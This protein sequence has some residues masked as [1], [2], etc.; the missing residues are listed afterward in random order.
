MNKKILHITTIDVSHKEI[1]IDKMSELQ[2]LGYEIDL[3]SDVTVT[4]YQETP[5]VDEIKR[6]G[7]T[8]IKV[9]MSRSI[10]PFKDLRSIYSIWRYLRK[11]KYSVVHT[12][13]AKAGLIGRIAARLA[14]Q[15]IVVHTSHGLPFYDGQSKIK[16]N[17]YKTLEKAA[18]YFSDGY[19]SQ[20]YEDLVEIKKIVPKRLLTGYEGNGIDLEKL[21]MISNPTPS[22]IN[23]FRKSLNIS[24]NDFLFLIGA[25]LEKVKNHEMLINAVKNTKNKNF[26]ILLAGKGELEES[27]KNK[28]KEFN[29]QDKVLFLGYRNDIVHLIQ[30][31][32]AV[33]LTSE[34]EGIPRILM[35]SMA[36][37]KPVL[38]TSVLGT[39]ELVIHNQTGELVTLND[40]DTLAKTI[41]KWTNKE[42]KTSLIKYGENGR[43]RIIEEYTEAK[44]AERINDFYQILFKKTDQ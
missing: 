24:K 1:M 25:R 18:S 12:H 26:K 3:M 10:Q 8:H 9:K 5:Y 36:F 41:D 23:Q 35:E 29:I 38:A 22:E 37:S 34:K 20:N 11:N 44:V 4:K 21:D 6:N 42:F 2:K 27:L 33:M 15:P 43:K 30:M 7:F 39:K 14:K 28:V 32:D 31:V 40:D 13:T 17:I 19:F 16:Y